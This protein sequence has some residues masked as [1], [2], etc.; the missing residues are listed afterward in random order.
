MTIVEK[1]PEQL[2]KEDLI[3]QTL[4]AAIR[5]LRGYACSESYRKAFRKAVELIE[6]LN[7][8]MNKIC[9]KIITVDHQYPDFR[10]IMHA[11]LCEPNSSEITLSEHIDFRWLERHELESLDWAAADLPILELL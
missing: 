8:T 10:L 11:Y 7:I 2:A 5:R 3:R 9:K 1:P 4:E 6:E